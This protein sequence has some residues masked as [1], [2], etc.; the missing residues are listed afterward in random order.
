MDEPLP[1]T[2]T[3]AAKLPRDVQPIALMRSFPRI[4]NLI[5]SVWNEPDAMHDYFTDLLVDRRGNREG[6]PPPVHAELIALRA[7]YTGLH[8]KELAT[9]GDLT[10]RS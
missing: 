10:K 7:Y 1:R 4:A 6:F 8:P 3:W 5:A 9:W 2:F